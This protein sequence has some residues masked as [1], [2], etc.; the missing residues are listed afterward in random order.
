MPPLVVH[1]MKE[2]KR[3][4]RIK[5]ASVAFKGASLE[6]VEDFKA[7][8][9]RNLARRVKQNGRFSF[10]HHA[11]RRD[12][13]VVFDG[14]WPERELD[15]ALNSIATELGGTMYMD[16]AVPLSEMTTDIRAYVRRI[17][18][19]RDRPTN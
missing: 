1:V 4:G 5:V 7:R 3:T 9:R 14:T 2:S 12:W 8:L 10:I 17:Y 6:V 15:A 11:G 13:I 19:E 18:E 16:P